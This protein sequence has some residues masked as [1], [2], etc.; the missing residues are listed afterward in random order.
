MGLWRVNGV[1]NTVWVFVSFLVGIILGTLFII[2][3]EKLTFRPFNW[4]EDPIVLNCYGKEL[5]ELYIVEAIH[6]W[7]IKG[8]SFS[9]IEN[10]PP[11]HLCESDFIRGFIMIKKRDLPYNTLGVTRRRVIMNKIVS[12]IIEFD[13]GTYRIDNV[14]EHELGHAIGYGHVEEEGH[15]M[16]PLWEKMSPK[17]WIPE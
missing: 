7:T 12:A 3:Y 5:D 4:T 8:H 14:F 13:A 17:F 2:S 1:L 16:H 10:N 6:Y 15:I 9:Y 11:P